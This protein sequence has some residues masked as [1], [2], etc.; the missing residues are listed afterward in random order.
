M[1]LLDLKIEEKDPQDGEPVTHC[2]CN[3]CGKTFAIKDC[4]LK[5]DSE[6]WEYPTYYYHECPDC[7]SGG[8]ITDYFPKEP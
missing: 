3:E 6:G 7:E 8:E 5:A 2:H 1:S 4:E